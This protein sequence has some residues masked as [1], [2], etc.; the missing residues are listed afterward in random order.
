MYSYYYCVGQFVSTDDI[1]DVHI[2]YTCWCI[3]IYMYIR[4]CV[5]SQ[6]SVKINPI[7]VYII[8]YNIDFSKWALGIYNFKIMVYIHVHGYMI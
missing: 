6:V 7:H 2:L 5:C 8:I 1:S 3:C 4:A